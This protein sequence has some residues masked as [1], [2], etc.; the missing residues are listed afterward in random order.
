MKLTPL[1]FLSLLVAGCGGSSPQP[2]S[3]GSAPPSA[4]P[5]GA[6]PLTAGWTTTDGIKT[7]ESVYYDSAS[8]FIFS[9]QIDGQ[10]DAKDGNGRI[11]KLNGDGSVANANF[12]TGLNAPK[13]IRVCNGTLWAADLGEVIVVD[14]A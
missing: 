12:V 6:K 5:T 2:A 1:V 3:E 10:P 8:G 14:V 11:V 13:G 9:S 7:P 4:A